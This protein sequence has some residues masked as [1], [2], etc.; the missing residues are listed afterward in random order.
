MSYEGGSRAGRHVLARFLDERLA[1]Y[2]DER[3]QP[4]ADAASGLSPWL[5][6]GHVSAHEVFAALAEREGWAPES[7]SRST[8]GEREGWWGMSEPVEAFLDELVTWRELG[9]N[10]SSRRA[11]HDRYASLPE[12][13]RATLAE[14]ASDRRPQLYELEAFERAETHDELWNAAQNQLRGEGRIHNYLRMLWGKKILHWSASPQEALATMVALNDKYAVDGRDPNSYSGI[15]WVLGR[16]DR[17]W[18]P[19][20]EVFG[21]VRYMSSESTR[22]KLRVDDYVERWD[23]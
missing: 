2:G 20:R 5:H 21:T 19:E 4:D 22:R 14:H 17:P 8:S 3:N 6:F 7:L 9:F 18:G 23:G 12:W 15:G 13:A 10:M 11:D 1:R 16:Y